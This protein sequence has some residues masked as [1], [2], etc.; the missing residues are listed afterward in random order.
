MQT[1][2]VISEVAVVV[3]CLLVLQQ[4]WKQH[5]YPLVFVWGLFFGSVCVA[6]FTGALRFA[7]VHP[8][9]VPATQAF[10]KIA[11][12]FG[13][14]G[15]VAGAY[16]LFSPCTPA[17][18]VL[19]TSTAGAV[20]LL[21]GILLERQSYYSIL[22]IMAMMAVL[23]IAVSYWRKPRLTEHRTIAWRLMLA[24]VVTALATTSLRTL[25]EPDGIDVFHY[26]LGAGIL[27]FGWAA[28]C[29]FHHLGVNPVK[30]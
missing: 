11:S 16:W 25:P 30:S 12:T 28:M 8:Y 6:A 5:G 4:V 22:Q 15:L 26:L 13:S 9:A 3:P 18:L 21:A 23:G 24:I 2:H 7:D 1:S 10:Q 27:C 17:R 29:R 19:W 20:C 14:C